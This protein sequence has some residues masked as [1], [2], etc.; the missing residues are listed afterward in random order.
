MDARK[1]LLDLPRA[2]RETLEKCGPEYDKLLRQARWGDGPVF[3]VGA[4]AAH[5]AALTAGYAFEAL[6]GLPAVVRA[7]AD[8]QNYVL[9]M[10][11]PRSILLALESPGEP[12]ATLE[13]VHAA[14]SRAAKVLVLTDDPQG[15][16]AKTAD[17]TFLVRTGEALPASWRAGICRHVA[18]CYLGFAVAR[19]LKRPNEYLRDLEEEFSTL[20]DHVEWAFT[21]LS[22]AVR[23]L[24]AQLEAAPEVQVV[25]GGF[26][27][28]A[29]CHA[30]ETFRKLKGIDA[31]ARNALGA[32]APGHG[33]PEQR[34][35]VLL[36]SGSRCRGRK[37]IQALA[38]SAKRSGTNF[39]A[40]TDKN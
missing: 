30:V 25:G 39:L 18:A 4:H 36:L 29:A 8:F 7:P 38:E 24:A 1:D 32:E 10:L 2:L 28:P 16:L 14:K 6:V 34:A 37:T 22:E 23:A 3:V 27:Y 40:V 20:P 31:H 26:Y 35:T 5:A 15:E 11:R 33:A 12:A 19:A 9:P 13:A 17:I 21:Q